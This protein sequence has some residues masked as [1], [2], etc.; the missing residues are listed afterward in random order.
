LAKELN[1]VAPLGSKLM[2]LRFRCALE[3]D[4]PLLQDAALRYALGVTLTLLKQAET[5]HAGVRQRG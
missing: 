4:I 2:M 1:L 5:A 3:S